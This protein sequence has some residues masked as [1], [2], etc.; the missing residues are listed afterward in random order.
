MAKRGNRVSTQSNLLEMAV[1]FPMWKEV[2]FADVRM[3]SNRAMRERVTNLSDH[4][5]HGLWWQGAKPSVQGILD[6]CTVDW[7]QEA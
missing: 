2:L 1:S 3:Q 4:V 5:L 6:H 7:D